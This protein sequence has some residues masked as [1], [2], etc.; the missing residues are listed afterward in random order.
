MYVKGK[1]IGVE[2]E[3]DAVVYGK[4]SRVASIII[5]VFDGTMIC[6]KCFGMEKVNRCKEL[7]Q[8]RNETELILTMVGRVITGK[9]DRPI[10]INEVDLKWI[11]E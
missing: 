7:L 5:Q 8:S 2:N 3:A 9:G 6:S 10:Y 11:L 1:I 4:K